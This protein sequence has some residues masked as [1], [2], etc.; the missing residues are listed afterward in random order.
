MTCA[1]HVLLIRLES[2][3]VCA[4]FMLFG[5]HKHAGRDHSLN[6][7]G[8]CLFAGGKC[9]CQGGPVRV[10][11]ECRMLVMCAEINKVEASAVG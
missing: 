1:R 7:G 6:L 9:D 4:A 2:V 3:M 10:D 11:P 5:D 8:D